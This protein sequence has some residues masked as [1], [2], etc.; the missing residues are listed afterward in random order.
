MSGIGNILWFLGGGFVMG[1]GWFIAGAVMFCTIIGIPWARACFTMGNLA[2]FPFG[3]EAV[4]RKELSRS[5]DLGTG[6]LGLLGNII[7][8]ILGGFWLALGHA[9]WDIVFAVTVIGIPFALQHL[10]LANLAIA[11]VGKTI[12]NTHVAEAARRS[13]AE[14]FIDGARKA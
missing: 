3:R 1:L 5:D 10:K 14:V 6:S 7:W 12:V 9:F 4:S 13:G 2:F 11:P 8:F